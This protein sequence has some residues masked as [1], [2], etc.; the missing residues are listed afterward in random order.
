MT[1]IKGKLA[2]MVAGNGTING[3]KISAGGGLGRQ[4]GLAGRGRKVYNGAEKRP[5]RTRERR[6]GRGAMRALNRP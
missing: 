3:E 5:S 6:A 1:L 2:P 4:R